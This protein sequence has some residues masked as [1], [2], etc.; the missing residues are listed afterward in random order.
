MELYPHLGGVPKLHRLEWTFPSGATIKFSHLQYERDVLQHQS[1]AYALICFEEICHYTEYQWWYMLSRNRTKSR[2]RPYIRGTCNPDP[3]SFV[4]RLIDWWIGE[5]GYPIPERGGVI[6]WFARVADELV[7][8]DSCEAVIKKVGAECKPRSFTFIPG[9]LDDNPILLERDPAYRANLEALPSVLRE[10]LLG[11]NWKIRPTAGMYF[12]RQEFEIID[13]IPDDA[14]IVCTV[15]AWDKAGTEPHEANKDP[16]YTAGVK[17]AKI[18]LDGEE[19]FIV[20]DVVRARARP[21]AIDKLMR[22][23]AEQDGSGCQI[24]VFQD[25]GQAGKV[26]VDHMRRVL[27]GFF[28]RVAGTSQ[29]KITMAGPLSSQ[30]EAGSVML[31]RG[32][33]ND[34]YLSELENF[35]GRAHDDQV[36]ASSLAFRL[37]QRNELVMR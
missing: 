1:K 34:A 7:W 26:D 11:G 35:P 2:V 28:I 13:E 18:K 37:V 14:Q 9:K 24:G 12:K 4:A 36:D 25:P 3:D 32:R 33:W 15:R 16:D 27:A 10:Q 17:M 23:T 20:L 21:G 6:R 29:N 30:V 19:R 5:D 22:K 8:G 31:L